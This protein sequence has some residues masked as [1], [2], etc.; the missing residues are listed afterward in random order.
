[1]HIPMTLNGVM[2]GF[3][4]RTPTWDE[5]RDVDQH[6]VIHVHMTSD[7]EW[8]PHDDQH[9]RV[10]GTLHETMIRGMDF[11]DVEPRDLS[12]LQ[13]RGQSSVDDLSLSDDATVQASNV[14]T[15]GTTQRLDDEGVFSYQKLV[16]LKSMESEQRHTTALDV[17]RYAKLMMKE[18]GVTEK[19]LDDLA[20][21]LAAATPTKS[22]P[23]FV[24]ADQLAKNWKI[25]LDAAKRT[26]EAT[27]QLAVRDFTDVTG[28]KRLKPHHWVLNQIRLGCEVFTDTMFGRCKSLRGNICAQ[29][30]ATAFHYVRAFP[31]EARKDAHYSLDDF[32][33]EVGVPQVL[34]PDNAKELV[35]KNFKKKCR[36]AQCP[37]H[38]IEA[39]TPNANLAEA[40][41]RE[42][43]RHYR[44]VMLETGAP[45][46]LWDYFLEWCALIRSHTAL[47]IHE[48]GGQT[49]ATKMT[50]DTS[51]ISFLAEFGWYDWVWY[52]DPRSKV[53]GQEVTGEPSLD[54]KR[55]GRYLGPAL[56]VGDKMCGTILTE[57]S[58]RLQMQ[59]ID[60]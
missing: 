16:S 12:Q 37:I 40:V 13:V 19:G 42:L 11:H 30:F 15:K 35:G 55:L 8:N 6:N 7:I 20:H 9:S 49:P 32:F 36:R 14:S 44:R 48:L 56:N 57:R 34:V 31:M 2:S 24:D 26:V 45:E 29:I 3:T 59:L 41:I 54:K 53:R 60:Y 10:E 17:D 43:K 50:G 4:V 33:N 51:N 23:G 52:D 38:P 27:T 47:N 18:L 58:T 22:R 5:V 1:M 46:V 28:S 25:G 39:Y 21:K